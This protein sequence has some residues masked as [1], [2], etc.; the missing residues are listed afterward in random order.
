[1]KEIIQPTLSLLIKSTNQKQN[2]NIIELLFKSISKEQQIY[3]MIDWRSII[4]QCGFSSFSQ[5]F[6]FIEKNMITFH[7]SEITFQNGLEILH[8]LNGFH[9]HFDY[10][11]HCFINI[12]TNRTKLCWLFVWKDYSVYS[13][14]KSMW[15][16]LRIDLFISEKYEIK[17]FLLFISFSKGLSLFHHNIRNFQHFFCKFRKITTQTKQSGILAKLHWIVSSEFWEILNTINWFLFSNR[18]KKRKNLNCSWNSKKK[19]KRLH[20][21]EQHYINQFTFWILILNFFSFFFS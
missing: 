21:T 20:S 13:E 19:R 11:F 8:I 2:G 4:Q 1:L 17:I 10:L 3:E 18:K 15:E 12:S 9:F 16:I 14:W 6:L 7:E 5:F